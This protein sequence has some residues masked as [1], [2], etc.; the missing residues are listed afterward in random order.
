MCRKE[1]GGGG[2]VVNVNDRESISHISKRL[3]TV[4]LK[5]FIEDSAKNIK[6]SHND[7]MSSL[8]KVSKRIINRY[9]W[10]ACA[11]YRTWRYYPKYKGMSNNSTNIDREF[12]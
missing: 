11:V 1:E 6:K 3:E 10:R 9:V 8:Q 12:R 5:E 4:F 2:Q 7:K